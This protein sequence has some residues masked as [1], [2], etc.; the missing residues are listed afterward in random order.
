MADPIAKNML[1]SLDGSDFAESFGKL[2]Q[3]MK[4]YKGVA[5]TMAYWSETEGGGRFTNKVS[6]YF[7]AQLKKWMK[8]DAGE[9]LL[10]RPS[11]SPRYEAFKKDHNLGDLSWILF[12]NVYKNIKVIWRGRHGRTVGIQR[13]IKVPRIGFDFKAHG[14]ISIAKYAAINEFGGDYHP[15]RPLFMPA[16]LK[17]VAENFPPMVQ[18]VE[19]AIYNAAKKFGKDYAVTSAG[20]GEVTNVISEASLAG[21]RAVANAK[22]EFM[23]RWQVN[24]LF[25]K[26]IQVKSSEPKQ[27]KVF[28]TDWNRGLSQKMI[29][30]SENE[31]NAWLESQNLTK[32][33]LLK[34]DF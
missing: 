31:V 1:F 28:G 15:A 32:A 6:N 2:N 26:G 17:F 4:Y 23:F 24:D 12:E 33:D 18:T 5:T 30:R 19:N 20:V 8:E 3:S 10:Y 14:K 7:I 11:Y 34:G 13:N 27:Q 22:T 25:Q 21:T 29:E 16:M 9:L